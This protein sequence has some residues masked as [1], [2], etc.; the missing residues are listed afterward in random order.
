[1]K[2]NIEKNQKVIEDMIDRKSEEKQGRGLFLLLLIIGLGFL[3]FLF[4]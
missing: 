1:M 4:T 3:Y 2:T